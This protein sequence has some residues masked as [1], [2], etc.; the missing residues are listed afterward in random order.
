MLQTFHSRPRCLARE[1]AHI[2]SPAQRICFDLM[3]GECCV[4][5]IMAVC[6]LVMIEIVQER[7]CSLTENAIDRMIMQRNANVKQTNDIQVKWWMNDIWLQ[8][9]YIWPNAIAS[10]QHLI[11]EFECK[12]NWNF[13]LNAKVFYKQKLYYNLMSYVTPS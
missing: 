11:C 12:R 3:I 13:E 1:R 5:P 6:L 10:Q 9:D 2:Y 8:E 4:T 7:M